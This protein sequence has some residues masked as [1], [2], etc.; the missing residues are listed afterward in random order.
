MNAQGSRVYYAT[1]D[2]SWTPLAAAA[3]PASPWVE[4][5]RGTDVESKPN[6]VEKVDNSCLN[7]LTPNPGVNL[8]PGTITFSREKDSNTET[9]RE[10]CDALTPKAWAQVFVD[11]TAEY[12]ASG[13]LTVTSSGKASKGFANKVTESYEVVSKYKLSHQAAAA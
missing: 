7:D 8:S 12:T 1:V 13:I 2:T 5:T 6:E 4:V 10:L 3:Y 9:L 11:G